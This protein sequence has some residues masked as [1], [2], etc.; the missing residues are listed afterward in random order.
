MS[1]FS[2]TT[3]FK[4]QKGVKTM[5]LRSRM[6]WIVVITIATLSL[7]ATTYFT[8]SAQRGLFATKLQVANPYTER[9]QVVIKARLTK[10][11]GESISG[12]RLRAYGVDSS[13]IS[14]LLDTV[15]TDNQGN[16][17]VRVSATSVR[18]LSI[19]LEYEGSGLYQRPLIYGP[20]TY[21]RLI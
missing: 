3:R 7:G 15:Y 10:T 18:G 2:T 17:E 9:G 4:A 12:A 20:F 19:G 21:C 13:G 1:S 16:S 5:K 8:A 6:K 14:Y 11:N